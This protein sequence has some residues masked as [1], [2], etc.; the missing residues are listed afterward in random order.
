MRFSH[1]HTW[2]HIWIDQIC[3]GQGINLER[4]PSG[5]NDEQIYRKADTAIVWLDKDDV[6]SAAADG[7]SEDHERSRRRRLAQTFPRMLYSR[8]ARD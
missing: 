8:N 7:R 4:G 3:I 1:A 2:N 5:K 6:S